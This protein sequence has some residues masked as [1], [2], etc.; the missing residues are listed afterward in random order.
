M[1][2]LLFGEPPA[3]VTEFEVGEPGP[4]AVWLRFADG[5]ALFTFGGAK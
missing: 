3:P 4:G 1:M 2:H 5:A